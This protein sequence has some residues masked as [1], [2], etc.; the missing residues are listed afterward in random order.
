M[1]Q[2]LIKDAMWMRE[3]RKLTNSGH[4]TSLISTAYVL[5]R[6]ILR[7]E[8][9][10]V[11]TGPTVDTRAARRLLQDLFVTETDILPDAE[12]ISLGAR[13]TSRE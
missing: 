1:K 6:G 4:Q 11:G 13:E 9:S 7:P 8:C 2:Q 3:V 12:N 10:A 5:P